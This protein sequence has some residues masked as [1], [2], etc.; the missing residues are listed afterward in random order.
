VTRAILR[1]WAH[2]FCEWQDIDR[3]ILGMEGKRAVLVL[4]SAPTRACRQAVEIIR[5]QNVRVVTFPPHL[6]HI[7][8]P[9]DV[10]WARSFK[11]FF[12][13]GC[14][15]TNRRTGARTSSG[16]WTFHSSLPVKC[17]RRRLGRSS[18]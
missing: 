17:G 8:Q 9:I 16:C 11:G 10:L 14:G 1:E 6:M 5:A 4:D 3:T 12:A 7:L 15:S 2:L 18:Q 13:F